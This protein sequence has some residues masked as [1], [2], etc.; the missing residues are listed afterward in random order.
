MITVNNSDLNLPT[1]GGMAIEYTQG[2]ELPL[3]LYVFGV[4]QASDRGS[5]FFLDPIIKNTEGENISGWLYKFLNKMGT[6]IEMDRNRNPKARPALGISHAMRKD[7]VD[8]ATRITVFILLAMH[9]YVKIPEEELRALEKEEEENKKPKTKKQMQVLLND[10]LSAVAQGVPP[11]VLPENLLNEIGIN[12]EGVFP[13]PG[14]NI[15][16]GWAPGN[17]QF[18]AQYVQV[19]SPIPVDFEDEEDDELEDFLDD[20]EE[21]P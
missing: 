16:V 15:H 4:G 6:R 14:G 20:E 11:P 3:N 1:L 8:L 7:N 18:H 19:P 13:Q 21:G 10:Y 2:L 9:G 17:V 5:H 12:L